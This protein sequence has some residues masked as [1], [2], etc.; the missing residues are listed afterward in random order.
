M[1]FLSHMM[2]DS[3]I[4]IGSHQASQQTLVTA[5]TGG[6]Q[7]MGAFYDGK[8]DIQRRSRVGKTTME[9]RCHSN[10]VHRQISDVVYRDENPTSFP[11][12]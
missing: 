4:L 12:R 1:D 8:M 9:N 5:D 11:S 10:L 7:R 6:L 2:R 3:A